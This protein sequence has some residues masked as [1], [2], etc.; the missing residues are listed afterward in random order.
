PVHFYGIS[1]VDLLPPAADSSDVT[2]VRSGERT[3]LDSPSEGIHD[4]LLTPDTK[5]MM[6]PLIG[7][8]EPGGKNVEFTEHEGD[9]F[10]YILEG[11]FAVHIAK[12]EPVVLTK[13]DSMYFR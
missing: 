10:I 3:V 11:S 8:F 9:E 1:V 5:R 4:F 7:V 2:V 6:L 13:G 12:R